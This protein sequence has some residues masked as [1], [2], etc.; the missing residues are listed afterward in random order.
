MLLTLIFLCA[1]VM[2]S[3][4]SANNEPIS[5]HAK[6]RVLINITI[7]TNATIT[8][9]KCAIHVYNAVCLHPAFLIKNL[10]ITCK[11]HA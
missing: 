2:S 8:S 10:Q 5:H 4:C 7:E 6:L 9:I 1:G 3:S 11:C